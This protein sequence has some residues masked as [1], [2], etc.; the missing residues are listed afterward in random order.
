M[1]FEFNNA[2][3][4]IKLLLIGFAFSFSCW[5][6]CYGNVI[7]GNFIYWICATVMGDE[8]VKRKFYDNLFERV[9]TIV[10]GFIA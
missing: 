5:R 6:Q 8:D 4:R 3:K 1:R 7:G 2:R 9:V 10:G